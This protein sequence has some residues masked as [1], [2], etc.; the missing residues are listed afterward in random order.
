[1]YLTNLKSKYESKI[2]ADGRDFLFTLK[3]K[4]AGKKTKVAASFA[5][6]T[7]EL[8]DALK[9]QLKK[10]EL[11][12][13][14]VELPDGEA[15]L[16]PK[17]AKE[18][19]RS[20]KIFTSGE[21]ATENL[22]AVETILKEESEKAIK[23]AAGAKA[24]DFKVKVDSHIEDRYVAYDGGSAVVQ[25]SYKDDSKDI[26]SVYTKMDNVMGDAI[27]S[28]PEWAFWLM[29]D[30]SPLKSDTFISAWKENEIASNLHELLSYD[31]QIKDL[32]EKVEEA[33][34]DLLAA[35]ED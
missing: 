31:E 23:K 32:H 19:D 27:T 12:G 28:W 15:K 24:K 1:M 30:A 4:Y 14:I 25:I 10:H 35:Y 16:T 11:I 21:H 18:L 22:N 3:R 33:V 5:T 26:D 6:E 29:D 9:E 8:T 13:D 7:F 2:K 17:A 34:K 20:Y